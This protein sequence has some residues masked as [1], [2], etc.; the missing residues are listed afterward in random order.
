MGFFQRLFVRE[1][2]PHER[3]PQSTGRSISSVSAP[4]NQ[5]LWD[6]AARRKDSLSLDAVQEKYDRLRKGSR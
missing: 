4:F 2:G 1:V 3:F 5:K 6:I